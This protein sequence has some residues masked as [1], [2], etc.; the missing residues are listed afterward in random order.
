MLRIIINIYAKLERM[1][2]ACHLNHFA[3]KTKIFL[4]ANQAAWLELNKIK[5][6]VA[7]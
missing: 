7:A 5:L 6:Q 2:F 3:L 4:A 1:K